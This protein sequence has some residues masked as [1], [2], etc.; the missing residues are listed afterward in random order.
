MQYSNRFVIAHFYKKLKSESSACNP[1]L[2]VY[3]LGRRPYELEA[4]VSSWQSPGSAFWS[5]SLH[6]FTPIVWAIPPIACVKDYFLAFVHLTFV[7]YGSN[8]GAYY[9]FFGFGVLQ[10]GDCL[11]LTC[12]K[13]SCEAFCGQFGNQTIEIRTKNWRFPRNIS[14]FNGWTAAVPQP[15]PSNYCKPQLKYQFRW[16]YT[17]PLQLTN[18]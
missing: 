2:F 18:L 13:T 11:P 17:Y 9:L 3:N 8:L 7:F 5:L 16:K 12:C 6:L 10:L 1:Q 14:G 15:E 4:R